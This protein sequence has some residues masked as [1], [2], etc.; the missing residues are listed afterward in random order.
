AF[1]DPPMNLL[2]ARAGEGGVL[3]PGGVRLALA[4]PPALARADALTLGLRASV[5]RL[6]PREGDMGVPG[7]VELAEISGSDT[8]VHVSTAWGEL[9]A[10]LTGVHHL[11]LGGS[12]ALHF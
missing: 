8:F 1:S 12:V 11:E 4:L 10:Q 5:L 3:L 6:Q 2:P 9:V 7:T